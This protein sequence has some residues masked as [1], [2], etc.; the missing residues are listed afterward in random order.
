VVKLTGFAASQPISPAGD[1]GRYD[2]EVLLAAH[3]WEG[4]W[5]SMQDI[6]KGP[7]PDNGLEV[8]YHAATLGNRMP[9]AKD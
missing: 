5:V 4:E 6:R 2:R 8:M 1:P 3:L 9:A 7:P